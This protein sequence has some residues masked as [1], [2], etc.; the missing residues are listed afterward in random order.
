MLFNSLQFL[1]FFLF[2]LITY[3]IL[4]DRFKWFLLLIASAYFY[5][6]WNL[7]LYVLMLFIICINFYFSNKIGVT[8]DEKKSKRL[9]V[10]C[11]T[12]NMLNLF[13]FKY[14]N[15]VSDVFLPL[16]ATTDLGMAYL[17]LKIILP[18]GIS[19]YTFQAAGYTI[20]V[21]RKRVAP[22]KN[23]FFFTLFITFFPQLVAGPIERTKNLLPQLKAEHPFDL[24]NLV[25][26]FKI[27]LLGYF[28]KVVIADRAAIAVNT[29]LNDPRNHSS[30]SLIIA[31]LLF[32]IQ[33]YGDFS[34]Y[35]DIARGAAKC[36]GIDLMHNF[37]Q[38]YLSSS[39]K[40]FWNRWHISLSTWFKDYLY[41]PLGG[42][43][44]KVSRTN[45]NTFITFLISGIWHGANWTFLVWGALH[46]FILVLENYFRRL[47]VSLKLNI[48]L[49]MIVRFF[50]ITATF[51]IVSFA[52]IF[53]RA[54]TIHDALYICKSVITLNS[55]YI[56]KQGIYDS[57]NSIGLT[58][59]EQLL[60]LCSIIF[61]FIMEL[62][63]N[64]SKDDI[65]V[66]LKRK[67]I[68]LRFGFYYVITVAVLTLGVF[69]SGGQ[70]IYFQF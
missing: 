65:H 62:A 43:R 6:S 55:D 3:Y 20:D 2:V 54:N 41:I 26:G 63:E 35:S 5:I 39:L 16:F 67:N 24:D 19:F 15:F 57:I 29:V 47:L 22:E 50:K 13:I 48:G 7:Y 46:G 61:L 66:L 11:I 70:F 17:P 45:F 1:I 53:F 60:L 14:L 10:V 51:V 64:K 21:Y 30:V 8:L 18:M 42:S 49:N 56:T 32:T 23:I 44:C 28:K 52:W 34:G 33:I 12:I 36:L 69:Y 38:P 58:L 4:H 31:I 40:E 59:A 25:M 68:F 9:L 37:R 27:M